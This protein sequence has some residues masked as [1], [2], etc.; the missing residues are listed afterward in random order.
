MK[1]TILRKKTETADSHNDYWVL[2]IVTVRSS[3]VY[4]TLQFLTKCNMLM[5]LVDKCS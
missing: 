3:Y 2:E 4:A 5:K 1:D